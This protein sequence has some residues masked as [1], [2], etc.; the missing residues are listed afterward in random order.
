MMNKNIVIFDLDGTLYPRSNAFFHFLEVKTQQYIMSKC[1]SLTIEEFN[2]ME[3]DIP[4]VI[5]AID[6]LGI[7]REN[8]YDSVYGD[9]DYTKF[10]D[11]DK[12]LIQCF[13]KSTFKQENFIVTMSGYKEIKNITKLLGIDKFITKAYSPEGTNVKSKKDLYKLIIDEY[14]KNKYQQIFIV[15][16]G[17]SIDILP[18]MELGIK[19]IYISSDNVTNKVSDF[20]I[21]NIYEAF[22]IL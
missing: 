20:K 21:K 8:F 7:P 22:E 11:K 3:K 4:S 13:E 5:E 19:T 18:A 14:K 17:Y 15:G 12:K 2:K 9:I 1:P 10:F 16:D 6:F